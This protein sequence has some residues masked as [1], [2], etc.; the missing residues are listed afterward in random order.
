[1]KFRGLCLVCNSF[2]L[3]MHFCWILIP[4]AG[5]NHSRFRAEGSKL[6]SI[7]SFYVKK[8]EWCDI[9]A[10]IPTEEGRCGVVHT[11]L[12]SGELVRR[13]TLSGLWENWGWGFLAWGATLLKSIW[14]SW[15][16][17]DL[18]CKGGQQ[19]PGLWWHQQSHE[20]EENHYKAVKCACWQDKR[21]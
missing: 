13:G 12:V 2:Y 14:R 15:W 9:F 20:L 6:W 19:H 11:L 10:N 4:I 16:D 17:T 1:M 8:Q 18:G 3:I 7:G 5:F 21:W